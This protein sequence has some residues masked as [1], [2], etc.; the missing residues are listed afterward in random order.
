MGRSLSFTE[1]IRE[2]TFQ[3]MDGDPRV[4]VMG[5]GCSYPNGAD[6]TTQGLCELFPERVIDTPVSGGGA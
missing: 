5:L 6:G 3:C 1:A 4:F 2:S